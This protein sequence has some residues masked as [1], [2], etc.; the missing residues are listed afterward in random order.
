MGVVGGPNIPKYKLSL[1][2]NAEAYR[3]YPGT[4]ADWFDTSKSK[5]TFSSYGTQLPLTEIDGVTCWDFNGSGYWQSDSGDG[6]VDMGGDCTLVFWMYAEDLTERDTIF[7]KAG[8]GGTSYQCE[9][10]MTL[11]TGES[12]SYYS[13]KTPNYDYAS[14]GGMT[15]G[16][17]NLMS[18]KMSTGRT[19][20]AR[21]G[22]WSKNGSA[23]ASSYSS[24][25]DTPL[26]TA[27]HIRIGTG[28]A[29]AVENGYL[30]S[31]YCYN[32]ML[33]DSEI[34]QIYNAT[35]IKFGL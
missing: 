26:V 9:I 16:Q 15:Q 18:I 21:T 6:K 13:R 28:Y 32:R 25:S 12:F 3:S 24:R 1:A 5:I 19:A 8:V 20:T 10:A 14:T 22:F 23:Y 34:S 7:E 30:A 11:E 35:K 29:G 33:S 2:V 27:S 4:G 17:W 31:L